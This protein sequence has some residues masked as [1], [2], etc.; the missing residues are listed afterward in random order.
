MFRLYINYFSFMLDKYRVPCTCNDFVNE[1][2]YGACH[3]RDANFGNL[4]TCFV[5]QTSSCKD[6][7]NSTTNP[8][9]QLSAKACEDKNEGKLIYHNF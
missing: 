8:G 4:F 5:N 1:N 2:G 9:I 3:K 6:I 7:V